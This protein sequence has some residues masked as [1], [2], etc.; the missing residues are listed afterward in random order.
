MLIGQSAACSSLHTST[1]TLYVERSTV[2]NY[3]PILYIGV[4]CLLE[5]ETNL[6]EDFTITEKALTK[7]FSRLK[8]PSH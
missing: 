6:R 4:G 7:A 2:T 8:M 3:I 1:K 5:L